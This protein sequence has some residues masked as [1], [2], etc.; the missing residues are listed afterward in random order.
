MD[1]FKDKFVQN[2]RWAKKFILPQ[3]ENIRALYFIQPLSLLKKTKMS[4]T[5]LSNFTK[6]SKFPQRSE[7]V[8][9]H[10]L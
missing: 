1:T 3:N 10:P 4:E 5:D 8:Q 9:N 2:V 7:N 6:A